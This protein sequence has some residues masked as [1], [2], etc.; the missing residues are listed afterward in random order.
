MRCSFHFRL[1]Y[2]YGFYFL[3]VNSCVSQCK[4]RL[5]QMKYKRKWVTVNLKSHWHT[6]QNSS[7]R[8][9]RA[10]QLA[11]RGIE[12]DWS[13]LSLDVIDKDENFTSIEQNFL[14]DDDDRMSKRNP[15]LLRS[16]IRRCFFCPPVCLC[17]SVDQMENILIFSSTSRDKI[18]H[19]T[20]IVLSRAR[21]YMP[22]WFSLSLSLPSWSL[23]ASVLISIL[24]A[25][26]SA[27]DQIHNQSPAASSNPNDGV[28]CKFPVPLLWLL[29]DTDERRSR[30]EIRWS[31]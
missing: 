16:G 7:I 24:F 10:C 29:F 15:V 30:K 19:R 12:W 6:W 11:A 18:T 26:A 1:C 9:P 17:H 25:R 13:F 22:S 2:C 20:C 5:W 8:F 28:G 21:L 4:A 23:Y 27:L 14:H 3:A 31:D